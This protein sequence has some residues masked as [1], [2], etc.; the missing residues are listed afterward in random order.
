MVKFICIV[1][2][3]RYLK[4]LIPLAEKTSKQYK[5]LAK[6]YTTFESDLTEKITEIKNELSTM[7]S[8]KTD[9]A[10]Q[11]T[12][13]YQNDYYGALNDTYFEARGKLYKKLNNFIDDLFD[14]LT[15][16]E[17]FSSNAAILAS[18]YTGLA[19]AAKI[20]EDEKKTK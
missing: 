5:A 4:G 12:A 14:D 16:L 11:Q 17:K 8:S 1:N 10:L 7:Q 6:K 9:F 13:S 15:A 20:L 19:N 18:G 3:C 2:L